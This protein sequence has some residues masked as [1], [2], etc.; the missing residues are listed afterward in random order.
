MLIPPSFMPSWSQK[1]VFG[2]LIFVI[3][4]VLCIIINLTFWKYIAFK[5]HQKKKNVIYDKTISASFKKYEYAQNSKYVNYRV[6]VTSP[7]NTDYS[8]DWIASGPATNIPSVFKVYISSRNPIEYYVKINSLQQIYFKQ[9]I[10]TTAWLPV[11]F[12]TIIFLFL[13]I[14]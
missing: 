2:I 9:V 13:I 7:E 8:S 12:I 5:N 14:K 6:I 11:I 1:P 10:K 4:L 3:G